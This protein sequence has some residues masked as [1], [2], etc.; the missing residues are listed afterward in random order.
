MGRDRTIPIA[1]RPSLMRRYRPFA[2][3]DPL[4]L[5]RV[6]RLQLA[7]ELVQETPIRAVGEDLL[8]GRLDEAGFV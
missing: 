3:F 4:S 1:H 6:S 2:R 5:L 7:F 8:W